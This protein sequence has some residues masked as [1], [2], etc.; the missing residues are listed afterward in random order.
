VPDVTVPHQSTQ[1]SWYPARLKLMHAVFQ[2][3]RSSAFASAQL[4][5]MRFSIFFCRIHVALE[6]IKSVSRLHCNGRV[7]VTYRIECS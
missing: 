5:F 4:G 7:A 3:P 6:L 2:E 1:Q